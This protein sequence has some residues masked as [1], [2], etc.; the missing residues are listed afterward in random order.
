M[1]Q[2]KTRSWK[3]TVTALVL[4]GMSFGYVE[5]AV[6]VYLRDLSEPVRERFYPST[7]ANDLFPVLTPRE[8]RKADRGELWGLVKVEIPREAATLAM[9]AAIALAASIS[10]IEGVAAFLLT[11]GVWDLAFY[12]FLKMLIGWPASFLTW[13]LLFLIPVPW[14]GPVLAPMIVSVSMIGAGIAVLQGEA[15]GRLTP[16]RRRDWVGV[17]AGGIIIFISFTWN[18]RRIIA[19]KMP[20]SFEWPLF[21]LGEIIGLG[22]FLHRFLRTEKED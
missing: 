20:H 12:G 17:A 14:S 11:F 22:T 3:R 18:S 19:G 1:S 8:L 9:L 6:V 5:A 10:G 4:F 7:T 16:W 15:Q 2:A 13:D 21:A